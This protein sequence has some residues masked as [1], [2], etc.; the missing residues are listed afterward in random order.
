LQYGPIRTHYYQLTGLGTH[1]VDL[2]T[3]TICHENG[4]LLCRFPDMYDYGKRD[5]DHEKSQG[6]GRYC[7]MGSGNHLNDRRT[8]SPVCAYLRDLAGWAD[9]T[10]S[11]NGPGNR[12]AEH[13]AYDVVMKYELGTPNEYFL[14]E[15]RA[16]LGLDTHLPDGGL[17]VFHCDTLGSNEWQEGTRNEH[18]QCGLV[19]ADGHL[20]LEN[21]RNPGDAG[22]LFTDAPGIALSHATVPDSRQWDGTDSGLTISDVGRPERA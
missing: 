8:P 21:N 10:V 2:R 1:P 13:G 19:Q 3:G 11:L 22:D 20:D 7:L 4:H 18:Y 17:A 14:V 16:Q 15:N 5:G 6:I 12:V 9:T